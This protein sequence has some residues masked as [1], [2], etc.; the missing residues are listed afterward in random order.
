MSMGAAIAMKAAILGGASLAH[1][2]NNE[3]SMKAQITHGAAVTI[4]LPHVMQFELTTAPERFAR[5]AELMGEKVTGLPV[6]EAAEKAVTAVRQLARDV[7]MASTLSEV[8]I[9]ETDISQFVDN[10]IKFRFEMIR[11]RSL[12]D[13]SEKD[14]VQIFRAAL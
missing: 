12:R 11:K 9:T 13:V 5:I 8:G 2:I 3:V 1:A 14:L 6:M 7:G 10:L 4:L